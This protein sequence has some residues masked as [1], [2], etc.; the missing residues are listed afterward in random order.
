ML[1]D[2]RE[3]NPLTT[4]AQFRRPASTRYDT[5]AIAAL[6][7]TTE[8]SFVGGIRSIPRFFQGCALLLQR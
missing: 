1:R 2:I 6:E 8:Q 5:D 7:S 4:F 3:R